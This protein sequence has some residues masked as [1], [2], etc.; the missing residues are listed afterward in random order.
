MCWT[1]PRSACISATTRGCS[2]RCKRLR[3]LGNTVIVVEHDEDAIRTADH[4]VDIGPGAGIHGGK[5]VAAGHAGRHHGGQA[6][7]A[8]RRN[9]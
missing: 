7:L 1:S 4:V 9:I 5:I 3:D 8:D 2:K 6:R